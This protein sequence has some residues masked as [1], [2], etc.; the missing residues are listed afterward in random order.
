NLHSDNKNYHLDGAALIN[1]DSTAAGPPIDITT[2]VADMKVGLLEKYLGGVFT[3]ITG[4]VSGKLH[5]TGPASHLYYLGT[6]NLRDAS[7]KVAFTQCTYKIANATVQFKKDTIDFGTIQVKDRL[8]H[9]AELTRGRLFHPA[10]DDL[11]YDFELNTN[12][13][14]LLVTKATDNNPFSRAVTRKTRVT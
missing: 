13:G 9:T 14:L 4:N 5:I 10:F 1:L 6:V 12:G 7:L 2:D 3:N 11:G 8:G